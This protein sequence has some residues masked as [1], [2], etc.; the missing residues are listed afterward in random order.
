MFH[1]HKDFNSMQAEILGPV[2]ILL[3]KLAVLLYEKLSNDYEVGML[4][5]QN[6]NQE[7][8]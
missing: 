1:G 3:D 5:L 4:P 6:Y 8:Y 2:N 7:H